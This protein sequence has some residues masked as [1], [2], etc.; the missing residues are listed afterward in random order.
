MTRAARRAS[1]L[2]TIKK[3]LK[4]KKAQLLEWVD[5]QRDYSEQQLAVKG[6][7]RSTLGN[8]TLDKGVVH[9]RGNN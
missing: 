9:S 6:G 1:A 4:A 3:K 7:P 8:P 5:R 2:V